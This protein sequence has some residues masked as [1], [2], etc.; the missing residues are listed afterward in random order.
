MPLLD[1]GVQQVTGGEGPLAVGADVS[2]QSVVVV[3]IVLPGV[4]RL[5]AASHLTSELRHPGRKTP[6]GDEIPRR[7]GRQAPRHH[8]P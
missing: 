7:P 1:V 4:K 5:A 3:L 6:G 2:M 8:S